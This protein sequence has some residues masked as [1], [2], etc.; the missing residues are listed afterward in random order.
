MRDPRPSTEPNPQEWLRF[1]LNDLRAA[2]K[3]RADPDILANVVGFHAK[4]AVEKAIKAL[5]VHAGLRFPFTHDLEQLFGFYRRQ[6]HRVPIDLAALDEL[7]PYAGHRRYPGL[8]HQP[9]E[10]EIRRLLGVAEQVIAWAESVINPPPAPPA[11]AASE[12]Q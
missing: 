4:Q 9:G 10:A 2:R 12:G 6:G 11:S 8:I 1:A 3:L 5:C 7:T